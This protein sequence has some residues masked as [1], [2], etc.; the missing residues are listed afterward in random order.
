MPPI[1]KAAAMIGVI[2]VVVVVV[3]PVVLEH[4]R[5]PRK[6]APVLFVSDREREREAHRDREAPPAFSPLDSLALVDLSDRPPLSP[7]SSL[8]TRGRKLKRLVSS[9]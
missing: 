9:I 3:P 1:T 4:S 5:E 6:R 7:L 8:Q 2:V